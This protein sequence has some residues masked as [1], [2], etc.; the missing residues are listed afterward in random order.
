MIFAHGQVQPK[1]PN[2]KGH[3]MTIDFTIEAG[4]LNGTATT[5][6]YEKLVRPHRVVSPL[7]LSDQL[8]TLAQDADQAGLRPVASDLL[9]LALRICENK[10]TM[11]RGARWRAAASVSGPA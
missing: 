1:W 5:I 7:M 4:S 6:G 9:R 8:M 3:P 2:Q 10:P 11:R